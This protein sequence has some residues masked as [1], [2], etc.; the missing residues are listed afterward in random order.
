VL[1]SVLE[2]HQ[3]HERVVIVV[4]FESLL[5]EELQLLVGHLVVVAVLVDALSEI[6]ENQV[7][8]GRAGEV[9]GEVEFREGFLHDVEDV[10]LRLIGNRGEKKTLNYN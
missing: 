1:E 2:E 4:F 9:A 8:R 6:A 10:V 3:T 5:D 7:L